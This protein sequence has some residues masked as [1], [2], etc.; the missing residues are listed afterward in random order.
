MAMALGACG[1]DEGSI[2]TFVHD[3]GGADTLF[4]YPPEPAARIRQGEAMANKLY[5][6]IDTRSPR[7]PYMCVWRDPDPSRFRAEADSGPPNEI[8]LF[9]GFGTSAWEPPASLIEHAE[10]AMRRDDAKVTIKWKRRGDGYAMTRFEV[11]VSNLAQGRDFRSVW[12]DDEVA[13]LDF[14]RLEIHFPKS[15]VDPLRFAV[16]T[17]LPRR[18]NKFEAAKAPI[19]KFTMEGTAPPIPDWVL[20]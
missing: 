20:Y 5:G 16:A 15:P 9:C 11:S 2:A 14:E 10:Q 13:R 18:Y 3:V 19:A 8:L 6:I 7:T 4:A 12:Y 1:A 17:S